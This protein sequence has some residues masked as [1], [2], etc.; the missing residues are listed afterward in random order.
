MKIGI[1]WLWT[2]VTPQLIIYEPRSPLRFHLFRDLLQLR[3]KTVK[4]FEL[5]FMNRS[6]AQ[7]K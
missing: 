4:L 2:K 1:Q 7:A 5:L 6:S 3:G